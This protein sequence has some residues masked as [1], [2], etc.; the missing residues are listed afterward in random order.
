AECKIA[1]YRPSGSR[2]FADRRSR[3]P[4]RLRSS[5]RTQPCKNRLV[6][7]ESIGR[8]ALYEPHH[9]PG[10]AETRSMAGKTWQKP[11]STAQ[12]PLLTMPA[13]RLEPKRLKVK[14]VER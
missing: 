13:V 7:P 5:S 11:L 1:L 4:Q 8:R 10:R 6:L 2:D 14:A 12:F 3:N 9:P